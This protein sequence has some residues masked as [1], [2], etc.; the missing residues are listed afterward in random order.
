MIDLQEK[1]GRPSV[2]VVKIQSQNDLEQAMRIRCQVF[3]LEQNVPAEEE[4]D[5]FEKESTHFLA[6]FDNIPCGAARWRTT[7]KGHKLERF[8]VLKEHRGKGVGSALIKAVLNDI[9][10]IP[11][12][13]DK[14]VYLNA[15]LGAAELYAKFGFVKKGG[16]FQECD[17]GHIKMVK[18][19][20]PI[21][22]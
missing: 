22:G 1:S 20:L 18:P 4:I 19:T 9:K 14:E 5:K 8:A 7:E 10:S 12:T 16:I 3:V 15:Q 11:E 13:R 21:I 6:F 2:N 17:I